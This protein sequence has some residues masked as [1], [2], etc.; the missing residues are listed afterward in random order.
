MNLNFKP[1]LWYK[2]ILIHTN[3]I[4]LTFIAVIFFIF[5]VGT[6]WR[7]KSDIGFLDNRPAAPYPNLLT[8]ADFPKKISLNQIQS[9]PHQFDAFTQDH[10]FQRNQIIS[11]RNKLELDIFGSLKTDEVKIGYL[12]D[13]EDRMFFYNIPEVAD[14]YKPEGLF[15]QT[16]LELWVKEHEFRSQYFEDQGIYYYV[17]TNPIKNSVYSDY[18]GFDINTTPTRAK[19]IVE[20]VKEHNSKLKLVFPLAEVIADR[21]NHKVFYQTD[22]HWN[23]YGGYLAYNELFK[24]M[25]KDFPELKPI[26]KEQFEVENVEG[27]GDLFRLAGLYQPE[28]VPSYTLPNSQVIFSKQEFKNLGPKSINYINHTTTST[29]GNTDINAVFFRNS[30]TDA[31]MPFA[32]QHFKKAEYPTLSFSLDKNILNAIQPKIVV[33][34]TAEHTLGNP[35]Y[36]HLDPD[37]LNDF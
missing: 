24:V 16:D 17:L 28:L 19:Q 6:F 1:L 32:S 36:F 25:S 2:K 8:T 23:Q 29:G 11:S 27:V 13:K 7:I 22:S 37:I 5:P 14:L 3:V 31:I 21:A 18:L 34:S 9:F 20:Y 4:F 33:Q 15:S 12:K 35:T 26:P 30:F 10:L